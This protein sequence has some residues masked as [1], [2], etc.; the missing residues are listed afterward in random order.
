[1]ILDAGSWTYWA[2]AIAGMAALFSGYSYGELAARYP[3]SGGLTSYFHLAFPSK[4]VSGGMSLIYVLTSAISISMMAKS[5]G[6]YFADLLKNT[7]YSWITINE[8]AA[9]LI[10]GLAFLNMMNAD[11]VGRAEIFLVAVKVVV[12]STLISAA[13]YHDDLRL[14]NVLPEPS[15]MSFWGAIGVTFLLM[16]DMALLPM[17]Q[18]MFS[19]RSRQSGWRFLLRFW[20]LWHYIWLWHMW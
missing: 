3:V 12:L 17:R 7:A 1:M 5:F 18:R 11:D 14:D 2:F 6:I 9:A 8:F 20:Q 19:A 13:V 4:W 16:P 15:L 10:I